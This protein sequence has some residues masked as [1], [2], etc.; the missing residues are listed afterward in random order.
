MQLLYLLSQS[1]AISAQPPPPLHRAP[2]LRVTHSETIVMSLFHLLGY[3]NPRCRL[4]ESPTRHFLAAANGGFLWWGVS[5]P[6]DGAAI[7]GSRLAKS[8]AHAASMPFRGTSWSVASFGNTLA[9]FYLAAGVSPPNFFFQLQGIL[10]RCVLT[11]CLQSAP[12]RVPSRVPRPQSPSLAT[13]TL[14]CQ[15]LQADARAFFPAGAKPERL[16]VKCRCWFC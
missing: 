16:F 12:V 7:G 9:A 8:A 4:P 11:V 3:Y 6:P 14:H 1:S 13:H 10:Q 2:G 15:S 5:L